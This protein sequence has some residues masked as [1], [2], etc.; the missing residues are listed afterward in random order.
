MAVIRGS[1]A[2]DDFLNGTNGADT[3]YGGAGNDTLFGNFG[4]DTVFG[5][6]GNDRLDGGGFLGNHLDYSGVVGAVVA[7][8]ATSTATGDGTDLIT[9]NQSVI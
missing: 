2:V 9:T 5:G 6:A 8:L 1:D 4:D 7:N 3:M